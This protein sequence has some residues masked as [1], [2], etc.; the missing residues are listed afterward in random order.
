MK[1]AELLERYKRQIEDAIDVDVMLEWVE[2]IERIIYNEIVL[3]HEDSEAFKVL[4]EDGLEVDYF[5]NWGL[6]KDLI[7]DKPYHDLYIYYIDMRFYQL[8]KETSN[9]N[10]AVT[11]FNSA[12]QTFNNYYNRNHM[13]LSKAGNVLHHVLL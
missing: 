8:N 2:T 7:A 9:Y 6:D 11:M 5:A 12:Y 1:V 13:P 4:D 10:T 3:T